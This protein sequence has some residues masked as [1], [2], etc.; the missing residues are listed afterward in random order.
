MFS[1]ATPRDPSPSPS[2]P[3]QSSHPCRSLNGSSVACSI[4]A[5]ARIL[6]YCTTC[7]FDNAKHH[8]LTFSILP[9][10]D[11]GKHSALQASRTPL[12]L[13]LPCRTQSGRD[14][15]TI[16]RDHAVC[17]V[18]TAV[19]CSECSSFAIA[20][21]TMRS[22][23]YKAVYAFSS[24]F[25]HCTKALRQAFRPTAMSYSIVREPGLHLRKHRLFTPQC[26]RMCTIRH[27]VDIVCS[28]Y[29]RTRPN[30]Y[31]ILSFLTSL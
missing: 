18:V 28:K 29:V 2:V 23:L 6:C 22:R 25:V 10:S 19:L 9:I 31:V 5:A 30:E 13:A 27:R 12:P 1:S 17:Q 15:L 20:R 4:A 26:S 16:C 7:T 8:A 3:S 14:L 24:S 21:M 11:H